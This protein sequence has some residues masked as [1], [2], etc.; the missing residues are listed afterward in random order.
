MSEHTEEGSQASQ[1]GEDELI[2]RGDGGAGDG[3]QIAVSAGET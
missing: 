2:G 3:L 1:D